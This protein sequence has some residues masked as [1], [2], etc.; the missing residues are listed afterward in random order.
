L[1]TPFGAPVAIDAHKITVTKIATV[2]LEPGGTFGLPDFSGQPVRRLARQELM[3][4]I[5]P[6][7]SAI[8][9]GGNTERVVVWTTVS[10]H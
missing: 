4:G 2:A 6:I 7:K 9:A 5:R 3:R 1:P 8:G 10:T